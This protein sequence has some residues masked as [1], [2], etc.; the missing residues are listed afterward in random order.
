M[1][2]V[3]ERRKSRWPPNLGLGA[4]KGRNEYGMNR[5]YALGLASCSPS[6]VVSASLSSLSNV[7]LLEAH[8]GLLIPKLCSDRSESD[9]VLSGDDREDGEEQVL[10]AV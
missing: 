2:T 9:A 3:S 8:L 4:G 10:L 6:P 5:G 1:C 7:C